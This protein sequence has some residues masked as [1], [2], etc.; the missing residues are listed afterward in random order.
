MSK[1]IVV[2]FRVDEQGKAQLERLCDMTGKNVSDVIRE[3]LDDLEAKTL[4]ELA[5]TAQDL[6]DDRPA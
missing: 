6:T 5:L 3:A 4:L 2:P 1:S